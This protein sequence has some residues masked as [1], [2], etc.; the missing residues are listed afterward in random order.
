VSKTKYI[1]LAELQKAEHWILV[2]VQAEAF[3]E[4]ISSYKANKD[5]SPRSKLKSLAPFMQNG[6]IRVGG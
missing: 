4:E 6:L 5:I 2:R 3:P 1:T